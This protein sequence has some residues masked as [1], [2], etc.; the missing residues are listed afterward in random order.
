MCILEHKLKSLWVP[1]KHFANW[2]IWPAFFLR[3]S[4][5]DSESLGLTNLDSRY[6]SLKS[7]SK[8][9]LMCCPVSCWLVS[10][11]HFSVSFDDSITDSADKKIA[12]SPGGSILFLPSSFPSHTSN[13]CVHLLKALSLCPFSNA[14][15]L[16]I[17][18]RIQVHPVAELFQLLDKDF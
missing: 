15:Q 9:C 1:G 6:W 4:P 11:T 5:T 16:S 12:I 2:A 10:T 18:G 7:I 14:G 8:L 13:L 17:P 3:R